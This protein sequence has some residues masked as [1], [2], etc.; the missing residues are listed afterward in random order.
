LTTHRHLDTLLGGSVLRGKRTVID[1]VRCDAREPSRIPAAPSTRSQ[2]LQASARCPLGLSPARKEDRPGPLTPMS[3]HGAE[4]A[5][6]AHA[7]SQRTPSYGTRPNGYN[8][9]D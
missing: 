8:N 6:L 5:R 7:P 1:S 9:K 2:A 4:P 3:V